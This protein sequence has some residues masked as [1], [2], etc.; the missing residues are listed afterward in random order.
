MFK[1][2]DLLSRQKNDYLFQQILQQHV[3]WFLS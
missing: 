2:G 3:R 1:Q